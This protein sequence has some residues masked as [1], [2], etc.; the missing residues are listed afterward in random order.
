M[1]NAN[2]WGYRNIL[3]IWIYGP[4][5]GISKLLYLQII[6]WTGKPLK[7][8]PLACAKSGWRYMNAEAVTC[9]FCLGTLNIILPSISLSFCEWHKSLLG[10]FRFPRWR[11]FWTR[12]ITSSCVIWRHAFKL[13]FRRWK[14]T[15]KQRFWG[16]PL[17]CGHD[18]TFRRSRSGKRLSKPPYYITLPK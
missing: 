16:W 3:I 2:E 13:K 14:Q 7:L 17:T 1:N 11:K 15:W 5:W 8:S 12:D 10:R 9:D 6:N 4:L 18:V